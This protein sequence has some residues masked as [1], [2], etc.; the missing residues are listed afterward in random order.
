MFVF[1]TCPGSVFVASCYVGWNTEFMLSCV[2]SRGLVGAEAAP[3]AF[4]S[5]LSTLYLSFS[6]PILI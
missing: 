1:S 5:F 6:H 4:G 2:R 3:V